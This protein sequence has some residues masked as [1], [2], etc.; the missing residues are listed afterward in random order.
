MDAVGLLVKNLT[1]H[2]ARIRARHPRPVGLGAPHSCQTER[3]AIRSVD[4]HKQSKFHRTVFAT[5]NHRARYGE[6]EKEAHTC[7]HHS[8]TRKTSAMEH[9]LD[10]YPCDD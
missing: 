5:T 6:R 9:P 7:S 1:T 4:G 10:R 3:L 8:G 2:A